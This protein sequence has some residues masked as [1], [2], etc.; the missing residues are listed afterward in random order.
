MVSLAA[1]L[2]AW[3]P[4][5]VFAARRQHHSWA[6]IAAQLEVTPATAKRPS[7]APERKP[8]ATLPTELTRRLTSTQLQR[9]VRHVR[10]RCV[11]RQPGRSADK[12][13]PTHDLFTIDQHITRQGLLKIGEQRCECGSF[14]RRLG[15]GGLSPCCREPVTVDELLET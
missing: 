8:G 1:Q 2:N 7:R 11:P 5:T 13:Q 10:Y 15:R 3:I 14:M 9:L 6:E 12:H 4:I